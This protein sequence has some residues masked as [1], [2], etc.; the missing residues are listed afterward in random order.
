MNYKFFT[1]ENVIAIVDPK[2]AKVQLVIGE[3]R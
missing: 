3:Q 2:G 1:V